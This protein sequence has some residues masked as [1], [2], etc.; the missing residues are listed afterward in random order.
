MMVLL[1]ALLKEA[2]M[3]FPDCLED[4][5]WLKWILINNVL[6]RVDRWIRETLQPG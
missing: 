4:R 6:I 1:H 2:F 5:R 3:S